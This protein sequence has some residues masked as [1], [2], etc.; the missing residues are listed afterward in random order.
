M[1]GF[2]FSA[3]CAIAKSSRDSPPRPADDRSSYVLLPAAA[4]KLPIRLRLIPVNVTSARM[5][6]MDAS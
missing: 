3:S 4:A 6:T 5:R 1:A 2:V